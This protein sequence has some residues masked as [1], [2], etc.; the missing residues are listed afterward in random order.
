MKTPVSRFLTALT[1]LFSTGA[2]ALA[3]P[4]TLIPRG[5]TWKYLDNGS[6]QGTAWYATGFDDSAWASGAA[7]LGY[8]D[9]DEVTTLGYGPDSANKYVT[10]YFRGTFTVADASVVSALTLNL[11]RDDGA[12]IYVNGV[13]AVRDN[14]PA[15]TVLFNTYANSPEVSGSA[16][17][18]YYPLTVSPS[19]LVTGANTIAVEI[20][21]QR[22]NSSDISFNMDLIATVPNP[23]N[24]PPTVS[25]VSP[26]NGATIAA[27]A[28]EL[29]ATAADSDGTVTKVEFFNGAT[30]LGEDTTAPFAFSWGSV[31]PGGY[32]LT[33]VATDS[34]GA[35]TISAAVAITVTAPPAA[36]FSYT[37]NFDGLGTGTTLGGAATSTTGWTVLGNLGGSNS[38]WT[39]ATGI[40]VSG[41]QSA[42][43]AG[44]ANL[45]LTVNSAAASASASSN[46]AAYNFALATSTTDRALGT[47]P[48]S[49]A[50]VVLQLTLTNSS[51]VALDSL[52]IGYDIR[53]FTA[54]TTANEVP[55]YRLF[56]SL[57]GGTSW[58]NVSALNPALTGATVNVPNTAGVTTV[59]PTTV[60]LA[61]SWA[62]GAQIRFRWIDD[63]ATETSPDQIIALDN[64]SITSAV[65]G[66]PPSV[67][68]TAPT[69]GTVFA[70]HANVA[71]TANTS[72]TD[73]T[74]SK[75]E[76]YV[77]ATKLG[78]DA[79]A[80]F[81]F[82]WNDVA[83][84]AFSLTAKATDNLGNVA[85]SAPI[86]ISVVGAAPS[87]SLT[88]PTAGA[89]FSVGSA[90]A[91]E[92]SAS[93]TDGSI[94]KVEYF[95]GA[96][97]LGE[98]TVA[99]F[100]FSWSGAAAGP[101]SLTAKATDN[102]GYAT[103]SSAVA[104]T[105]NAV[106]TPPTVALT[107]PLASDSFYAPASV[108][109]AANA[110]DADGSI[111]KVEFFNGAAKLGEDTNAPYTFAWGSVSSGSYTL[112]A[113]ATDTDGNVV[114]SAS[115][116]ITV[117]VP[118]SSGTLS[119]S[120]YLN[121]PNHNS[122]VVRW[123]SSLSIVGRVRYGTSPALLDQY[124]DES[125]A[126][127]DHEV[128][129]SGLTPYTRYYYSVGSAFDTLTPEATDTTSVKTA[130]YSFPAPTAADYTFRTAPLPGTPVPT[131]IWLVG[132]CGRGSTSQAGGRDAYYNW[133]GTR[134]PDLLL[135][136]GDN[137]YNS[138][139]DTEYQTGY[140]AM[141]PTIFK[142]L[143]QWSTLGNH[144][145]NN[146]STSSTANFPYFDMFTFPI[147]GECGGIASGTERYFSFDYGNVHVINLDSQTSSRNTIEKN[148]A[149]GPMAAWLRQDLASTTAT[150]IIAIF[151]HPP[152]SKGSHDSDTE[153]QMVQMRTNFGPI[154][155]AGG[156]D[157]IITGHSHNYERSVLLDGHYGVSSTI[158]PAMRVNGGNGST[159]GFTVSTSTGTIRR[160]PA[161]NAVANVSGTVI[162]PDGAY[163]K[164]LT[165]PRDHFG[166]VY[167]TNGS[168]GQADGGSLN[169]AAMYINYNTVGTLNFDVDG[170]TLVA[171]YVQSGGTAPDNFT[172]T[173]I[174]AAD[175]DEDGISDEYE[176]A[177][178][179]NRFD[180]ADALVPADLDG[181]GLSNFLE[182]SL[183]TAANAARR[184]DRPAVTSVASGGTYAKLQLAFN[185]LSDGSTY[186]VQGSD[187]LKTWT[188]LAVNPGTLGNAVAFLDDNTS[189]ATRFLRLK[190]AR[191]SSTDFTPA[192]GRVALVLAANRETA[193]SLPLTDPAAAS[194]GRDSGFINAVGAS[195]LDSTAA[196]WVAGELSNAA[197]PFLVRIT[198][199]AA[200]GRLFTV[201]TSVANTATQL[202]LE[203]N[204][205]DLTTLG[206]VAGTDT[207]ELLP[208]DTLA[209]VFP[210]GTLQSGTAS[211]GD[212]VRIFNGTSWISHYHDGA[213]W[214]R[215]D[216]AAIAD[217]TIIRP[218]QG[219][220]ILRR[221][222]AKT[223][224]NTGRAPAVSVKLDVQ[225]GR[226]NVVGG[227]PLATTFGELAIQNLPGWASN[228]ASPTTGD[229][230]Q[231]WN[232]TTWLVYYH[233]GGKWVRQGTTT[234]ADAINAFQAGRPILIRRPTGSGT[235][236]LTH[237]KTY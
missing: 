106:G 200:S 138:G 215:Q 47:S 186:T 205:V 141:Y 137:A 88:S 57:N 157:L 102:D 1:A 149:D 229:H 5:A 161:F 21:Q 187:D 43:T 148:G 220:L 24:V 145:A 124:V 210:T 55:G 114:T 14:L 36:A 165:G 174:G 223:L 40:P 54:P 192:E 199:G 110:N 104:I 230:V 58:T 225:R 172:I 75:V 121:S 96:T 139:T 118:P 2:A 30:K 50:G 160:G 218:D 11:L 128:K 224:V 19:L 189:S 219:L 49:G 8:G 82:T 226:S 74:I 103:T 10:S 15:G 235:E 163:I 87:V 134:T 26:A 17:S 151:H 107:S 191:G 37:Q 131:R 150:W 56:Y 117:A 232:G 222:T 231:I 63:N 233:D 95:A 201:S 171:T 41:A 33:A 216:T 142:K 162:P 126:R 217:N 188:D 29:T 234:S 185:R 31:A 120:P 206:M 127:T 156:V 27:T 129:L 99:P 176:I 86:A 184:A 177:N 190:V 70:P 111:T 69:A 181:D 18:T 16:E 28:V 209:T 136:L 6:D 203:T 93:D 80:P 44:T 109:L 211:T 13:E 25:I 78:E 48:T 71:I 3:A 227:L 53:R 144:D 197:T 85:T 202:T 94:S 79:V 175:S 180:P 212:L 100:S 123:R 108:N 146:G 167:A 135:M 207:F 77:G 125:A 173:K 67:S 152:Y 178:G 159:T 132:D 204:G 158:T 34:E 4:V 39:N 115:V 51:A 61:S 60:A 147:A 83:I 170:N 143:P 133:I 179:L 62:A 183:G 46:T 194:V 130:A 23:S 208:A 45:T 140:F 195:T 228:A 164:P 237:A 98:S 154:L 214:V 68:L 166:A 73:G 168:A 38:S 119:R 101:Y 81:E 236:Q 169:H 9:S 182:F 84:G 66:T 196:G 76:F 64:I 42:A 155:E 59:A 35:A 52:V 116:A 221:T 92:V 97:K 22:A 153:S 105:V 65:I 12:I 113:K 89:A 198:K 112:S 213:K 7:E 90:I 193:V 20:H 122:I 72:D 32:S 91:L